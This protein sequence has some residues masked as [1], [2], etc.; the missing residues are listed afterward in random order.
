MSGPVSTWLGDRLGTI[1]FVVLVANKGF[2]FCDDFS[3]VAALWGDG[4]S[5]P[6]FWA[7]F[8]DACI[9]VDSFFLFSVRRRTDLG[10]FPTVERSSSGGSQRSLTTASPSGCSRASSSSDTASSSFLL[11]ESSSRCFR[12]LKRPSSSSPLLPWRFSSYVSLI[13]WQRGFSPVGAFSLVYWNG[14]LFV[15]SLANQLGRAI[16]SLGHKG[17]DEV[18]GP[19]LD[20]FSFLCLLSLFSSHP[21]RYPMGLLWEGTYWPYWSW[22]VW[23]LSL[24]SWFLL[25]S[26]CRVESLDILQSCAWSVST[27]LVFALFS[28]WWP[29]SQFF[30]LV[31]GA[32][33]WSRPLCRVFFFSS[34]CFVHHQLLRFVFAG[35]LTVSSALFQPFYGTSAL[36]PDHGSGIVISF[37]P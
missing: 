2:V 34:V 4:V 20:A 21:H 12:G 23:F 8:G 30:R 32:S 33:D 22:E 27:G 13:H 5:P 14:R 17:V 24:L 7:C 6:C 9:A 26:V 16:T 15:H 19:R 10:G 37:L 28:L 35:V 3:A 29:A 18:S 31:R 11:A 36:H 1:D 25:M